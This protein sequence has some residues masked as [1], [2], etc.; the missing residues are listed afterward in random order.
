MRKWSRT[1]STQSTDVAQAINVCYTSHSCRPSCYGV[2]VQGLDY[3]DAAPQQSAPPALAQAPVKP[4]CVQNQLSTEAKHLWDF[5]KYNPKSFYGS[6]EDPI[7]AQM[8]LS[9]VETI[10]RGT[11][12]WEMAERM[13]GGDVNRITWKQFKESFDVKF[14]SV[15][16]KTCFKCRQKGHIADRCPMRLTEVAQNQGAGTLPVLGHYALVL[17]DSG[18]SHSFISSVFVSHACLEVEPLDHV[19]SVSTPSRE[20][21]LSKEKIK[22][23][24]IEIASH[25][26]DVTL[27]VLDMHDFDVI[28]GVETVVLPKVFSATKVSKL[29]N[30]GT[31]SILASVV[32]TREADVSLSSEPVDG[33]MCLCIDY[34]ELNK[35]TVKNKY[36][37]PRIDDLFDQLQGVIVF[38]KID[39]RSR[40]HQLRIKDIPKTVFRSRCGHYKF[41]VMS[42]GL[43]NA[44]AVFMD[45]MNRV[46]KDFLDTFVIV[47]IHNI[48]V[49]SKTEAEHEEHLCHV[50]SKD[51]VS[52]DPA[53]IEAVISWPDLPQLVNKACENSFQNLKQKLVTAPVVIVLDSS[54]SF[55]IDSDA[56]KKG[57]GCVLMQQ[58]N[59]LSRKVSHSAALITRQAPL[60]RD[61]ERAKIAVSVGV[62]TSQLAQLSEQPT[63]RQKIIAAQRNDPYLIE[64]RHLARTGQADGFSISSD[65]GLLFERRL[66]VPVDNAVKA[67]RQKPASVLQPL[68]VLEWKC[69][70]VS[71][72][73]ITVSIVSDRDV[74]FTSKFLKRLETAMNTRLDFSTAFHPQTDGQ[75]ERLNQV[76]EDMLRACALECPGSWDCHLHLM[77]FS[78]NNS[79]Q[80]TIVMAPFETLYGKCYRPPICW[81]KVGDQRQKSYA[82]VRRKDL[83]FDVG[84][85]VFL[86]VAPMKGVLRFEKKGKLSTCFVKPFEILE[87]IGPV[88]YRLALQPSLC[89]VHDM[90]HVSMLRKYVTDPSHVVDY[91]PLVI[92]E[93]LS[94]AEQS[95]EIMAKEV[96][97]LRNRG[98]PLVKVLMAESQR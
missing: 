56:S 76:L 5:R 9:S 20:S 52:V 89:V 2:K 45:L 36:S 40:Y 73:F 27:L 43:T 26:I 87:R 72:D 69:E 23:C 81:D 47:F 63:L 6:L 37:L 75:T 60:H 24:Q 53:K 94:Y 17:F 55:V 33:S 1:C 21:M 42:F 8:Q 22:A 48:L 28:L 41:I 66:C 62:V 18:S 34:K 15:S 14:F 95:V 92:D 68:N 80:P 59:A 38:S 44:P 98:I 90:F 88:A 71:M 54:G 67:P 65:D 83:E 11:S 35:V 51:G 85:K 58:A 31:Q 12:W 86:K 93:N 79:F 4:H 97:M 78:Y 39:L 50:V 13:L 7:K 96:K 19:L 64:K 61:Q 16:V 82:N 3:T 77:E 25:A 49:Y 46:F 32:D 30:Q 29:R 57:L 84:D 70:N 91:E 10:F 74:R